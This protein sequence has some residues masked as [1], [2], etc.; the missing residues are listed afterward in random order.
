MGD[1]SN[2]RSVGATSC[3]AHQDVP[4]SGFVSAFQQ[5]VKSPYKPHTAG[6][7]LPF[8]SRAEKV[9]AQ[10]FRAKVLAASEAG[11]E[12]LSHHEGSFKK[13]MEQKN[14]KLRQQFLEKQQLE[15]LGPSSDIFK[16]VTIFVNG[17][18]VP[19]WLE[20]K[21]L[22][23]QY[24]GKFENYFSRDSVTHIVCA[25]YAYAKA[26]NTLKERR[27]LPVVRPEWITDSIKAGFLV[28]LDNYRLEQVR[29]REQG[30]TT[31][32]GFEFAPIESNREKLRQGL[33][34]V[35]GGLNSVSCP[36]TVDKSTQAQAMAK[37][38]MAAPAEGIVTTRTHTEKLSGKDMEFRKTAST[39]GPKSCQDDPNFV[40]NFFSSSR[41]HHIGTWKFRVDNLAAELD[42]ETHEEAIQAESENP[43]HNG[44]S[45]P[46]CVM[47]VDMDCFFA[48]VAT[49]KNPS[50]RKRPIVVCHSNAKN[51]TGEVSSANYVA[52][53]FGVRASMLISQAKTLCPHLH[54]MA[55][56]FEEY[57]EVSAVLY[58]ILWR[59]TSSVQPVSCD[60][61]FLEFRGLQGSEPARVA[62][63]IRAQI[64]AETG[65]TASAGIGPNML[66]AKI[67]TKRAKPNGTFQ[68]TEEQA[69]SYMS[70]LPVGELPGVGY[71]IGRILDG[72][73]I[74][75]C[76]QLLA[77][78]VK[79][80]EQEVGVK[81]CSMLMQ[82]ARGVDNRPIEPNA[83]RKS[84]GAE[85]N[86]GVRFRDERDALKFI[87]DVA[88]EVS[89][90]M[91]DAS[92]KGRTI[93][94][95]IKVRKPGAGLPWKVL[96]HGPCDNHSKS[97]TVAEYTDSADDLATAGKSLYKQL[98]IDSPECRGLGLQVT[99]LDNS[100][101][102]EEH[103]KRKR[104]TKPIST[105]FEATSCSRNACIGDPPDPRGLWGASG[106]KQACTVVPAVALDSTDAGIEDD[107][108]FCPGGK[109]DEPAPA[110]SDEDRHD[111]TDQRRAQA[112]DLDI[113]YSK[114]KVDA[115]DRQQ[116]ASSD[117]E[118]ISRSKQSGLRLVLDDTP[119]RTGLD[120][121]Q[122]LGK[123]HMLGAKVWA[124]SRK[125][126][127]TY[128]A[129][130]HKLTVEEVEDDLHTRGPTVEPDLTAQALQTTSPV[131]IDAQVLDSLR[132]P[133]CSD[134]DQDVL[135][136]LPLTIKGE[137]LAAWRQAG[138][139]SS[140]PA[141]RSRT[142]NQQGR[143]CGR[144]AR[145]TQPTL[146]QM[147][148]ARSC[149]PKHQ[150]KLNLDGDA[151]KDKD[152]KVSPQKSSRK[153]LVQ[154]SNDRNDVSVHGGHATQEERYCHPTD[155]SVAEALPPAGNGD[156]VG[157]ITLS[158][159]DSNVVAELPRDIQ[160]E[161]VSAAAEA[162]RR[163]YW[164]SQSAEVTHGQG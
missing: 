8:A 158:Q 162:T 71:K 16:G 21:E 102:E 65:C 58:K 119:E 117:V 4:E 148:F 18:T 157:S 103:R 112:Q 134:V 152:E 3:G 87:E 27:P 38:T 155:Q 56:N 13:Y 101:K 107:K 126:P 69:E 159:L 80:L 68:I 40:A 105:F 15:A 89:K 106:D 2:E 138:T 42:R 66:T 26:L 104:S 28:P 30:Q 109:G 94:L 115:E 36:T 150:V 50:L 154:A 73:E 123:E 39:S 151:A 137:L 41:L 111:V 48:S 11:T 46:R 118:E 10:T 164:D 51:G 91:K 160:G 52:R 70:D 97:I 24:G 124:P 116:I 61:S 163:K 45:G 132:L 133:N 92:V 98:R 149:S 120:V 84:V 34:A 25:N 75:T 143:S 136:R 7:S 22:M 72:L 83:K 17:Y 81:T 121:E 1:A 37:A 20:L 114:K 44:L 59:H 144:A 47:H 12:K 127:D 125:P 79:K 140:S 153:G 33:D 77:F 5:H 43:R 110:H 86:W 49:R 19:S 93:T 147:A 9:P 145:Y 76:S 95:K 108:N 128:D 161:I 129:Y 141:K 6:I 60:E 35:V 23:A 96:G 74:K 100:S 82:Y 62:A 90:R 85:V 146:T 88:V 53:S 14:F 131:D 29:D 54:V 31:L 55:Y 142:G 64:E 63:K 32:K 78:D 122:K 130:E 139:K 57:R 156:V 135:D 67:A 99:R 113:A